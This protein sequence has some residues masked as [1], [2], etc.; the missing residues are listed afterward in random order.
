MSTL[1]TTVRR[2]S[3]VIGLIG[4]AHFMSHFFQLALAPVF[5]LLKDE[6][7]V[8]WTALGGVVTT[9]Y[10]FSGV[11]Q[12]LVGVWCDRYGA[13]R[14]L[15]M[16]LALLALS[17]AAAGLVPV[18]WL[19]YPLAAL[20]GMGNSVF[21]P[22]D[23]SILSTRVS[24]GRLG[25]AYSVHGLSG[26]LGYATSPMV[27]G[28]M[29]FTIG[30]RPALVIA[31]VVGLVALALISRFDH[32]LGG[33]GTDSGKG[34]DDHRYGALI[35][36]P[37]IVSGFAFFALTAMAGIGFQ[38]FGVPA[39]LSIHQVPLALATTALTVYLLAQASGIFAGGWIVDWTRRHDL[40]AIV[41]MGLAGL[42][43][44]VAGG[45]A[46]PFTVVL[47]LIAASGFSAGTVGPARDMLIR[48]A[49][50]AGATGKVFGFVYSGLDIGSCVGPIAFGWL[51][52]N[53]AP[54]LVF[55]TIA[56]TM[57]LTLPMVITVR[58]SAKPAS[59]HA[60]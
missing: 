32:A 35:R 29:A 58:R 4:A 10:A 39:L 47:A 36:Q 54:R 15:Y 23:L 59:Q 22:A 14:V 30:W 55:A 18:F 42:A 19:L 56:V 21:H 38:S 44:A 27:I 49:A 50:P 40:I 46:L 2:D 17:I 20:A 37:G 6:F 13:A 5:P 60:D 41:G 52:D 43:M 7:D 25:R 57:A 9:F 8:S 33:A 45:A 48:A 53:D 12:A 51:M 24:Q 16:G 1:A 11:C 3:L 31:G 28:T 26:T 34:R